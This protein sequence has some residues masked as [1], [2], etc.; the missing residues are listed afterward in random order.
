MTHPTFLNAVGNGVLYFVTTEH[1]IT[2]PIYKGALAQEQLTLQLDKKLGTLSDYT[3][4]FGFDE[5]RNRRWL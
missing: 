3:G 1:T 2:D 4:E 5:L